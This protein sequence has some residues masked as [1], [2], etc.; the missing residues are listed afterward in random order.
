MI[1]RILFAPIEGVEISEKEKKFWRFEEKREKK[2]GEGGG[3]K[4][5][6]IIRCN[7]P[8]RA[9]LLRLGERQKNTKL[10]QFCNYTE[11]ALS[12][13]STS[14]SSFSSPLPAASSGR[15]AQRNVGN[16]TARIFK[17]RFVSASLFFHPRSAGFIPRRQLIGKSN[18]RTR[19]QKDIAFYTTARR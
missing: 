16:T 18:R 10:M 14:T 8:P 1:K 11:L 5:I 2:G 17:F 19:M 4:S 7:A 6:W 9:Y 13:S 12:S 3:E 15:E